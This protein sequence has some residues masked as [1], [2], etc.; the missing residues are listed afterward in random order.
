MP[1]YEFS[2]D[3]GGSKEVI[4]SFET[5]P[6]ECCGKPMKRGIGNLSMVLWKAGNKVVPMANS[7]AL[8]AYQTREWMKEVGS[9]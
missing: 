9:A 6:P 1:L 2:C 3:C 5:P 4:Q 8:A 7:K